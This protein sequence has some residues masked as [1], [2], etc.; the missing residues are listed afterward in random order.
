MRT[1][2]EASREHD[3]IDGRAYTAV[4]PPLIDV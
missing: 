4:N 1:A 2:S 3:A